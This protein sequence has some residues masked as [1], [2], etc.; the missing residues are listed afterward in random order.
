MGSAA[1]RT[2]S[3]HCG[4]QADLRDSQKH[5]GQLEAESCWAASNSLK[6]RR[7][8]R[9]HAPPSSHP[10]GLLLLPGCGYLSSHYQWEKLL[11]EYAADLSIL[12]E[13]QPHF[14]L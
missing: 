12:G 14:P 2:A 11:W 8:T 5:E 1:Q 6:G 10:H 13:W 9:V 7:M 3:L 4:Q